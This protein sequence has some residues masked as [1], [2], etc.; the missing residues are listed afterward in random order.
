MLVPVYGVE[1]FKKEFPKND[2]QE[3]TIP[4]EVNGRKSEDFQ[5]LL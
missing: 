2:A 4:I 5:F 1:R 3:C